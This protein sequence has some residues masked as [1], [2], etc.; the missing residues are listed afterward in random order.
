MRRVAVLRNP[1]SMTVD[2]IRLYSLA[3]RS[4]KFTISRPNFLFKIPISGC[5]EDGGGMRVPKLD[6]DQRCDKEVV[7]KAG[8]ECGYTPDVQETVKPGG[9]MGISEEMVDDLKKSGH[10]KMR[11]SH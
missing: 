3:L 5:F 7:E 10:C 11:R 9:I 6:C 2:E 1:L 8:T 4:F